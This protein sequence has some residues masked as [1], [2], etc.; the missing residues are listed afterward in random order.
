[1]ARNDVFVA[2]PRTRVWGVLS[3]L[4]TYDYWVVGA[5]EI[6][7]ADERFPAP[8]TRFHHAVAF[9]PITVKDHT[10]VVAADPPHRLELRA[11]A[12]P[13]GTAKV[14]LTLTN[15]GNGTRVE[16]REDPGDLLTALVFNPLTHLL[17]R[18]RN[19]ESLERLA[20]LAEHKRSRNG[21]S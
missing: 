14:V 18:G 13:L 20:L 3:D 19:E 8:G 1:M 5:K 11:K 16:M 21:G 2:A 7:D 9:G 17:V 6:R 15:E 12:R 10:E 4:L